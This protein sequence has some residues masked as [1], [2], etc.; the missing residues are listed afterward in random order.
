MKGLSLA[1]E[2]RGNLITQTIISIVFNTIISGVFARAIFHGVEQI[3]PWGAQGIVVDLVPTVFMITLMLTVILTLI[4]RGRLR[5]G[6]LP[7]PLWGRGDL[8]FTGWLRWPGTLKGGSM[9]LRI[10][11]PSPHRRPRLLTVQGL[12]AL[13]QQQVQP[14]GAKLMGGS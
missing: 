2:H 4:T 9:P 12:E 6:K 14:S 8:P 10:A 5:K 11:R 7:A 1:P 3:P 13:I